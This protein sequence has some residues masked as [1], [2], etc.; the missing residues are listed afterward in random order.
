MST[1]PQKFGFESDLLRCVGKTIEAAEHFRMAY[2]CTWSHAWAIRFTDRSRAFF[3][4]GKGSGIMNPELEQIEKS[5]IFTSDEYGKM[6]AGAKKDW[7]RRQRELDE[8]Q[9]E[10]YERLKKRFGS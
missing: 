9:R 10:E 3:V 7:E 8:R 2:G 5:N 6:Q 1:W 4:G